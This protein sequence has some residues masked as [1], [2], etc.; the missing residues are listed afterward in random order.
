MG[1]EKDLMTTK[2]RPLVFG[3]FINTTPCWQAS[4]LIQY[5]LVGQLWKK[6]S[7]TTQ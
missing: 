7:Q 2:G 6:R 4:V 1:P 5:C 3:S